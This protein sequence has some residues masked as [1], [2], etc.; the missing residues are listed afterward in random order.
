[1]VT[2]I[3][4]QLNEKCIKYT[5][6]KYKMVSKLARKVGSKRVGAVNKYLYRR[7]V[8]RIR[9]KLGLKQG[10]V[11]I[12][13]KQPEWWLTNTGAG[14][15]QLQSVVQT[16]TPGTVGTY[17]GTCGILGTPTVTMNGSYDIPFA[18]QFRL[19]DLINFSDITTL[20]DKYRIRAVYVRIIPNF[21]NNPLNGLFSYPSIQYVRD[22]DDF[23]PPTVQLLREKMGVK[24]KTFKPGQYVGIKIAYPKLQMSALNGSGG[25]SNAVMTNR[26]LDCQNATIPH[27]GIKGVISNMDLVATSTAKISFKFD[28]AYVVEAKDFQ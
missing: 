9:R 22:D 24:L 1:M 12:V 16:V 26:W 15:C 7:R 17:I 27:Y 28:V 20:A 14:T 10:Y 19:D 3:N 18:M 6:V 4:G 25:N 11:K 2:I 8:R 21:T 23:T 5:T 13:R